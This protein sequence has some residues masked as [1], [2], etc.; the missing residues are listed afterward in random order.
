MRFRELP[1]RAIT[2]AYILHTG[3]DKWRG[4]ETTAQAV[5]AM[6]SGSYPVF[7]SMQPTAF[8]R[9][10][11]AGEIA[12]GAALLAPFVPTGVAGAMLTGF[13]GS[14][15]G[16]YARTPGFRRPGSIWPTPQGIAVSKDSWLLGVGLSLMLDGL[17][18][19]RGRDTSRRS[20]RG[21]PRRRADVP[22]TSDGTTDV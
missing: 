11:A 3:I 15:L 10:L 6:A 12:T 5:H 19:R 13:S 9:L 21:R 1:L 4:D 18:D 22:S 2:G 16:L 20:E 17:A 7:E 8:L 14:L